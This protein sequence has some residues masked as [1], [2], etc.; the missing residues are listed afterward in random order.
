MEIR[1]LGLLPFPA[2][3]SAQVALVLQLD[4]D[5]PRFIEAPEQVQRAG[6]VLPMIRLWPHSPVLALRAEYALAAF[7]LIDD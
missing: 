6:L 5:A 2:R 3:D 1:G 4:E 7:G